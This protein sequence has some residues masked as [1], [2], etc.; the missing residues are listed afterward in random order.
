MLDWVVNNLPQRR[1]KS[2]RWPGWDYTTAGYYFTTICVK[3]RVPVFGSISAG[4]ICLSRAGAIAQQCWCEIPNH[5]GNVGIDEF[6]I[7]LDHVHGIV[8][9]QPK[10]ES[11]DEVVSGNERDD[12]LGTR[13]FG[14]LP[15]RSLSQIVASYKSAVTRLVRRHVNPT[16]AW[17][18]R[19]HDTIIRSRESLAAI[20][21]Y[22]RYNPM[23]QS[24]SDRP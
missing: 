18:G 2:P 22:V 19:Y 11:C 12:G 10:V 4:S 7:M 1:R 20:R 16:F 14:P 21:A 24:S 8:I 3:G 13:R 6:V 15:A 23:C 17:Q 9:L 5:Y